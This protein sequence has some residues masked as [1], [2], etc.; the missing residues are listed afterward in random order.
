[1]QQSPQA[2]GL[3]PAVH[4]DSKIRHAYIEPPYGVRFSRGP[5]RQ[6]LPQHRFSGTRP[7][8]GLK[9]ARP[10]AQAAFREEL[11]TVKNAPADPLILFEDERCFRA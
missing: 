4:W 6:W 3:G 2:V 8:Y 10:A 7:I 9:R 11:A 1:M 5:L